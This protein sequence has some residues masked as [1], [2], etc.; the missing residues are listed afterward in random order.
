MVDEQ[1][2]FLRHKNYDVNYDIH[3]NLT[4]F[5]QGELWNKYRKKISLV[6]FC[7]QKK[8]GQG[9][10]KIAFGDDLFWMVPILIL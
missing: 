10:P 8:L 4:P 7:N 1:W 9:R 2:I 6:F 5:I 3:Q